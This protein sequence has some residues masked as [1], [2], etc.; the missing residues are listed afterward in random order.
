MNAMPR[1][2]IVVLVAMLGFSVALP[3]TAQWKWRDKSGQTQYS[4][5]PPPNGTAEQDILQRPAV[6][7]SRRT[8]AAAAPASAAS[9]VPLLAPRGSDPELEAK[10]K[11][12]EQ[13][14]AD[15]KKADDA[16]L[17]LARAENCT[18]AKAQLRSVESGG[19][20]TRIN[21]QGEREYMD[22]ASLAT[23]AKRA[24]DIIA[25]DCN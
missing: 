8:V 25:S 6:A 10:R 22:D 3:A 23:E 2:N 18:R 11:K 17:A 20:I 19:R 24:R 14:S 5:L 21:E 15:K 4:D 13:E 12:V 16:R 1:W 9:G 7:S